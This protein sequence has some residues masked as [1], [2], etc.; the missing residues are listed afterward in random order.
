ME[1]Y[2]DYTPQFDDRYNPSYIDTLILSCLE[3]WDCIESYMTKIIYQSVPFT[4]PLDRNN[5]ISS[6]NF[7]FYIEEIPEP[8]NINFLGDDEFY[9]QMMMDKLELATNYEKFG[10]DTY[11][12]PE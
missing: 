9:M 5:L 10:D 11:L 7:S 1:F 4:S 8:E 6:E 3:E 2:G 12:L